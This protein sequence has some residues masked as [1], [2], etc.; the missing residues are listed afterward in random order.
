MKKKIAKW[1]RRI[2]DKLHKEEIEVIEPIFEKRQNI[3]YLQSKV[4]NTTHVT[5][6]DALKGIQQWLARELG[7][8]LLHNRL[9]RFHEYHYPDKHLYEA[10]IEVLEPDGRRGL[11]Y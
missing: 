3:I 5:D 7:R 11:Y 1:L 10:N 2:A 6:R 9:I 8:A 4:E